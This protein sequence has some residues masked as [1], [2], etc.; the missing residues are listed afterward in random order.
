MRWPF[1][2][3]IAGLGIVVE[4]VCHAGI[5]ALNQPRE[6]GDCF[7]LLEKRRVER[8]A[9]ALEVGREQLECDEAFFEGRRC[10]HV[11]RKRFWGMTSVEYR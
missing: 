5:Q 7:L 4:Q 1:C 3:R 10:G 8:F 9:V 2:G 6:L 11:G